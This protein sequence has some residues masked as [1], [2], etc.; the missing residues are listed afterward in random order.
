M[1]AFYAIGGIVVA[2][3]IGLILWLWGP[4]LV[5]V[6]WVDWR[7]FSFFLLILVA[8]GAL[9]TYAIAAADGKKKIGVIGAIILIPTFFFF[10]FKVGYDTDRQYVADTQIVKEDAPSY[11]ERAPWQVAVS[12]ARQS[13]QELRGEAQATKSLATEGEFGV[14]NT[15]VTRKGPF[16]GYE[17]VQTV[18]TPL[19]GVTPLSSVSSC[20]FNQSAALRLG[21]EL[22]H[23][24]LGRAV[25]AAA[26]WNVKFDDSDVYAYCDEDDTPIVVLPLKQLDGWYAAYWTAYGVATYNGKTGALTITTDGDEI[27]KIPGPVYPMTLA[28]RSRSAYNASGDWWQYLTNVSGYDD[29]EKDG[30]DPNVGNQTEFQLRLQDKLDADYVT[31]LTPRG[32][33]T[34]IVGLA[35]VDTSKFTTGTRNSVTVYPQNRNANSTVANN[36]TSNYSWMP[37]WASG[38]QIF[39][40]VP[41]EDGNWVA[42]L[43]QKQSVV[44]RAIVTPEGDVTLYNENGQEVT[45]S[46]AN[47]TDDGT[48]PAE[49]GAAADSD[50]NDLT[51]EQLRELGQRVLDELASRGGQ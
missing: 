6:F 42:S 29:T 1:K 3:I 13:M 48:E 33:S 9:I 39:E 45:R 37:D 31:P 20:E 28:E 7:S 14:W 10:S 25:Y 46:N 21:G 51:T 32:E 35:T 44:Y 41:G 17:A 43:G 5:R 47:S 40:I 16:N 38:L 30:D 4:H 22:P 23:N 27:A 18:D 2:A 34:T 26:P 11:S 50:L 19:F 8:I 49:P 24:D 12:T 15:L 36:I